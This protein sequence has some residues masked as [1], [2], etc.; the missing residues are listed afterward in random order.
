[1]HDLPEELIKAWILAE[2]LSNLFQF[3]SDILNLML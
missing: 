1:M 3:V 2:I